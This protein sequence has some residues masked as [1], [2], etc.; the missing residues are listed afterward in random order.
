M[1]ECAY[2]HTRCLAKLAIAKA[3]NEDACQIGIDDQNPFIQCITCKQE[4]K[5]YSASFSVL[6]RGFMTRFGGITEVAGPWNGLALSMF[7][8][9]FIVDTKGVDSSSDLFA[10]RERCDIDRERY[11]SIGNMLLSRCALITRLSATPQLMLDL[12]R[13]L[14][15]L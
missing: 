9:F 11:D 15:V 6:A 4:F 3:E 7:C 12:S 2:V 10:G 13:L 14:S 8:T 1:R 5:K